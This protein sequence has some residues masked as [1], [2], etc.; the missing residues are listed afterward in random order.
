MNV[1]ESTEYT[2]IIIVNS[3]YIT[4]I[5]ILHNLSENLRHSTFTVNRN[6]VFTVVSRVDERKNNTR[7]ERVQC[8]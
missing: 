4:H 2:Q 8:T 5:Y 7:R 3:L 6:I 1:V